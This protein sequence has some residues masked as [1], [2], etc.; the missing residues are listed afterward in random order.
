MVLTKKLVSSCIKGKEIQI[1]CLKKEL[2]LR[3]AELT[4]LNVIKEKL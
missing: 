2:I 3:L 1:D 4:Q